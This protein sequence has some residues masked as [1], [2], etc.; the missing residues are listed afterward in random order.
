MSADF[1]DGLVIAAAFLLVTVLFGGCV[2]VAYLVGQSRVYDVEQ[3]AEADYR[4]AMQD[5]ADEVSRCEGLQAIARDY[6]ARTD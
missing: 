2:W 5:L 6:G 1:V 4:K 3:L